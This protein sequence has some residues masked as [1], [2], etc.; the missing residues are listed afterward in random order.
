MT[1][2]INIYSNNIC[3]AVYSAVNDKISSASFE[4]E[5]RERHTPGVICMHYQQHLL[6]CNKAIINKCP[7]SM[8]SKEYECIKKKELL[9][10]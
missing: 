8:L 7:R 1:V 9:T 3:E 5:E 6:I 10:S 2:I 4:T